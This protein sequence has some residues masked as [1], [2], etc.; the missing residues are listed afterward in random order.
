MLKQILSIPSSVAKALYQASA[1]SLLLA[2]LGS[3]MLPAAQAAVLRS[4]GNDNLVAMVESLA[5][6]SPVPL[7][8]V[9]S[10]LG[11]LVSV[12]AI[13]PVPAS[14]GFAPTTTQVS[15]SPTGVRL[16]DGVYVYGET[17]K[18]DQLGVT[19]MVFQLK[20]NQVTGA[21]Y[22]PNSSFDCFKGSLNAGELALSVM[23][24]YGKKAYSHSIAIST[25]SVVAA[26]GMPTG[27][28]EVGLLGMNRM[29]HVSSNDQRLLK[30]CQAGL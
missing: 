5:N 21:V 2:G 27:A 26:D 19:Y 16:E 20:N 14:P 22:S 4:S 24:S 6:P 11:S 10:S 23:D 29:P 1:L 7:A 12:S 25:E 8:A 30:T 3:V 9:A 15:P 17:D 18:P 28:I 13:A